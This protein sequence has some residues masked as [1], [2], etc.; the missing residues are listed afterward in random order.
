MMGARL[1]DFIIIGAQKSA[2]SSLYWWLQDQPECFLA[3]PKETNFFSFDRDWSKGLGWYSDQFS[4][5]RPGAMLGE[6]SVSYTYAATCAIASERM[7]ATVPAARLVY[8]VR[9]PIERLRSHFRHEV[10]RNRERRPLGMAILEPDNAYVGNSCYFS[11]LRPYTERF[12][13]EQ[14][15]IV[16]FEDLVHEP[17]VAWSDVLR[18]LGLPE[19]QAPGTAANVTRENGGWSPAMRWLK[20][21]RILRFSTVARL[22]GPVRKVGRRLLISDGREFERKLEASHES[23]P[24]E[25]T[26]LIWRDVKRLERWLGLR[27]PLWP[28]IE[29]SP[30]ARPLRT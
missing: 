9:D 3:S 11:C 10:Q 17:H 25:I 16:R 23:I 24:E 30:E 7:A 6:A 19:R 29:R 5:A 13:R 12:P 21:K 8:V 28:A 14:I 26:D 1:P 20:E 27:S 4:A 22:P 2:T 15:C 18:F